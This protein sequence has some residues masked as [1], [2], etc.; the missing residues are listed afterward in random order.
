MISSLVKKSNIITFIGIIFSIL[1]VCFCYSDMIN[2]A[3]IMM[4]LGGICDAFDGPIARIINKDNNIYG[5]QLD[6]LA[7]IIC[8]GILPINICLTLGYK[9]WINIIVYSLFIICGIIRLAYYNVNSSE[10]EYFEGVP[11]TFSFEPNK[12]TIYK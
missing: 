5:V 12:V 3:V 1:G 10:K 11:I 7:D 4:I 2:Y 9:S 6:S 8:S